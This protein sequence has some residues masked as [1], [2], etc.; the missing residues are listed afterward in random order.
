MKDAVMA[1]LQPP[2]RTHEIFSREVK[3]RGRHA[4]FYVRLAEQFDQMPSEVAFWLSRAL[5]ES[6]LANLITF[7][8]RQLGERALPA[9]PLDEIEKAQ[10]EADLALAAIEREIEEHPITTLAEARRRM[11]EV[12]T[13]FKVERYAPLA[14]HLMQAAPE[15]M[16]ALCGVVAGL[17]E[18]LAN[19]VDNQA[20]DPALSG[21]LTSLRETA[22]YFRSLVAAP[23]AGT[24]RNVEASPT[25]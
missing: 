15:A 6:N 25:K 18:Q 7:L 23:L 12:V 19:W 21:K 20:D 10:V 14:R 22:A 4:A 13:L 11:L 24:R 9:A 5:I 17:F 16:A 3:L 2:D 1:G 8:E